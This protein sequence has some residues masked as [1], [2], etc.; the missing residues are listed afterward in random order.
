MTLWKRTATFVLVFA[1]L[2]GAGLLYGQTMKLTVGQLRAFLRSSI[3][4]KHPDKQVADYVRKIQLSE[5]LSERDI[6]ELLGEGLG[7][8]TADALRSLASFSNELPRPAADPALTAKSTE[9][10]MPVPS[11][12]EQKRIIG[13]AREIAL[14]YTKSLPNF[15]CLQV[16]RRYFD[17][18]GL[19]FFTQ[20]DTVASRLSYFDQKEDYKVI[21]VNNKLVN[22][23]L[24]RLGGA[25]SSGEFGTMM[26]EVFELDTQAE[27]WWAR[28]ARLRGR[29][30]HVFG[31]RVS[32]PRSKWH[33]VWQKQLD[34]IPGYT[35]LI[36]I[37][38]DVPTV[39]RLTLEAENMP[40]TFP[41]QEARTTLDYDYT[42]IS[43][44]EF[45]LPM[46]SEMRMR[47]GKMLVK[48]QTEFRNYR[49]F[50]AEATV[51]F[52]IPDALPEDKVQEEKIKQP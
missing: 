34:Y 16:T 44:Q 20:A 47:E 41:I 17:P 15:I 43:G 42:A 13:E 19:E 1:G 12:A 37:D 33:I 10:A 29:I 40:P 11:A 26:K 45:L 39:M 7:P 2:L 9:P 21:S 25:T 50:G 18:N 30:V 32:K 52:E 4:L 28:W 51:T 36:Y 8:R 3:Q 35:G 38:R 14:S 31:Y 27:F 24:D 5:R 6:E 49:K 22:T 46:R 23:D 48:N